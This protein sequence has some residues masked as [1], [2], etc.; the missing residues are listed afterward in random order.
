MIKFKKAKKGPHELMKEIG[1]RYIS[2]WC[3]MAYY[4]NDNG[5]EIM[6][7]HIQRKATKTSIT[8]L[9]NRELEVVE[10]CMK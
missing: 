3:G 1:Y 5:D 7:D 9:T 6:I 2:C 10:Q 8:Q 4:Q